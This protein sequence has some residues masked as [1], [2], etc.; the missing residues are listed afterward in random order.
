MFWDLFPKGPDNEYKL[1]PVY[2]ALMKWLKVD[3]KNILFSNGNPKHERYHGF[4]LYKAIARFS[5]DAIPRKEIES[6]HTSQIPLNETF[7]SID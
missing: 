3:D 7:L 6:L 2:I 1:N 4:Q 5:K